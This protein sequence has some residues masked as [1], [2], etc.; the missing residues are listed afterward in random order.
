AG[1]Y[2][3]RR[4]QPRAHR[5]PGQPE[6]SHAGP[7]SGSSRLIDAPDRASLM[8]MS[9]KVG[10]VSRRTVY[11][12]LTSVGSVALV[13]GAI[14]VLEEHV[15]VLSLAVL[16]LLAV[17]PVAIFWGLGYAV[18]VAIASM[19]AFNFFFLPPLYTLTVQDSRNWFALLVFLVTAVV[20]SELAARS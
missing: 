7:R 16:Y 14:A 10:W 2:R 1:S 17:L 19:F 9:T 3:C 20:V 6:Q 15:P 18:G 8:R 12:A 13:T 4:R 11:A 5:A